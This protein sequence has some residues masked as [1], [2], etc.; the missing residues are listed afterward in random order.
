MQL[1]QRVDGLIGQ[2]Q[3]ELAELVAIR[4][5]VHPRQIPPRDCAQATAWVLGKFAEVGFDDLRMAPCADGTRS[6]I[7]GRTGPDPA[8][9]T[10]LLYTHCDVRPVLD[11]QAWRTPPF[12]LTEV[13][14]RWYGQGAAY[15]KGAIVRHLTA[16][17][18]LGDDVPVGL[19][20][21]VAGGHDA[22]G[23]AGF[24]PKHVGP[25]RADAILVCHAGPIRVGHSVLTVGPSAPA[26]KPTSGSHPRAARGPALAALAAT[27]RDAGSRRLTSA[28]PGGIALDGVFAAA[29]PDAEVILMGVAEP[30]ASG[31][32]PNENVDPGDI[33]ATALTEATFLGRYAGAW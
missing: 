24:L 28:Q 12:E 22:G 21:V 7:G 15:C 20:L 25:L 32:G 6:V 8:G 11:E 19:R 3:A 1:R 9:P 4:S 5:V 27:L 26:G 2:A 17:R 30:P 23:L 33:A 14:G 29:Q 18:A 10:V 16:L 31:P 13:D